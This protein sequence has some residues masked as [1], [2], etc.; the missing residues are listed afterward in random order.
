MISVKYR[1]VY[2]DLDR[3]GNERFYFRRKG[4]RLVRIRH[5]PGTPEFVQLYEE[6]LKQSEAGQLAPEAGVA[7]APRPGTLRWLCV[8]Y[9]R[10]TDFKQLDPSTQKTRRARLE[11][12]LVEPIA[13]GRS[14]LF[15]D[16][17]LHRLTPKS[18]R[19]LRDRKADLLEGANNR[20]KAL[21]HLFRWAV[22]HE[23][24]RGNPARDVE[25][26]IM[27]RRDTIPGL[28]RRSS[29]MRSTM[30]SAPRPGLLSPFSSIRVSGALTS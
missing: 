20:V 30:R 1:Y 8:T 18:I 4:Q 7:G 27:L 24:M 23:H 28:S 14:E 16:F 10:S 2:E 17:P 15:A 3:H 19:V 26:C 9:F 12:C 13:P 21:R 5:K 22:R 6:L 25:Y 11:A 29:S